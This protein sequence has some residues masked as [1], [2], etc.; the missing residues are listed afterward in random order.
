M[1]GTTPHPTVLVVGSLNVDLHLQVDRHPRTGETVLAGD[2][3]RRFGGKG[4]NQAIAAA[5]AGASTGMV[6]AVGDDP[7]GREY[8]QR[9]A[10]FGVDVGGIRAVDGATTGTAVICV[11]AEHD[12]MIM[13]SP[14]ANH[15]LTTDDVSAAL[16][17]VGPDDVVVLQL[18]VPLPVVEHTIRTATDRG[19]RVVANLAPY[20]DLAPELLARCDPVVVNETEH[21]GLQRAG[22]DCPSLL[23][24]LGTGGS[25]WGPVA[26][27]ALAVEAVDSTGAGD[28]YV[29]TLAAALAAG[30]DRGESMRTASAA[31]ADCVAREGAQPDPPR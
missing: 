31:A 30:A 5:V 14:G 3:V 10:S 27:P 4:A 11:D 26:V 23:V 24:T 1:T 6:G 16:R 20:A 28:A 15:R 22:I 19:A 25:R 29:G 18:E 7:A 17:D 13:V 21:A 12:N 9:L 8:Q 2:L